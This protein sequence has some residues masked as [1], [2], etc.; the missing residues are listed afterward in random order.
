MHPGYSC[1]H[2]GST[3]CQ[4]RTPVGFP[5]DAFGDRLTL[6]DL[7]YAVVRSGLSVHGTYGHSLGSI[8]SVQW[9]RGHQV[10]PYRRC[11]T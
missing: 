6:A 11:C 3:Q 5:V 4:S 9:R 8:S 7:E 2:L 1:E 10:A